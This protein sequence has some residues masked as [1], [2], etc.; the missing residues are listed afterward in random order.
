VHLHSYTRAAATEEYVAESHAV[1]PGSVLIC[2]AEWGKLKNPHGNTPEASPSLSRLNRNP[3]WQ[4]LSVAKRSK[5][6]HPSACGGFPSSWRGFRGGGKHN[7]PCPHLCSERR[8]IAAQDDTT[9]A[10]YLSLSP[11]KSVEDS[12]R[13]TTRLVEVY[14]P[15]GS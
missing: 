6:H 14:R 15:E 1:R 8:H 10:E 4:A 5:F 9:Y 3:R 11:G 12:L 13:S 2:Y 7:Q